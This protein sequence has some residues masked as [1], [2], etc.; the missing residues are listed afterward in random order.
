MTF[1]KQQSP[2]THVSNVLA[3]FLFLS[4]ICVSILSAQAQDCLPKSD[5]GLCD[6]QAP[7]MGFD[8]VSATTSFYPAWNESSL[9]SISSLDNYLDPTISTGQ[10]KFVDYAKASSDTLENGHFAIP[11][12]AENAYLSQLP[13]SNLK[14]AGAATA[15]I[16]DSEASY[17]AMLASYAQYRAGVSAVGG[18]ASLLA[19]NF[20]NALPVPELL[21]GSAGATAFFAINV[22]DSHISHVSNKFGAISE[23]SRAF[24]NESGQL[25][26]GVSG[27]YYMGVEDPC[28]DILN[29][30]VKNTY[31]DA[32]DLLTQLSANPTGYG[33][34]A[35]LSNFSENDISTADYLESQG[36]PVKYTFLD[37]SN[38]GARD[39]FNLIFS[40]AGSE[41]PL[42]YTLWQKSHQ[43]E[44]ARSQLNSSIIA[45]SKRAT[46]ALNAANTS[47][48]EFSSSNAAWVLGEDNAEYAQSLSQ[49]DDYFNNATALKSFADG[50]D[51]SEQSYA[52]RK[53][54]GYEMA[55]GMFDAS[56]STY[57]G[58]YSQAQQDTA[59][60]RQAVRAGLDAA[61]AR[62]AQKKQSLDMVSLMQIDN[63]LSR[64]GNLLANSSSGDLYTD[65]ENIAV[66]ESYVSLATDALNGASAADLGSSQALNASLG[67]LS[68]LIDL[69]ETDGVD[70]SFERD[71]YDSLVWGLKSNISQR[72]EEYNVSSGFDLSYYLDTSDS[73]YKGL[74]ARLSEE[75]APQTQR[76][77]AISALAQY[78]PGTKTK[79]DMKG[80]GQYF[81][82]AG[83]IIVTK[84]A[85][86]MENIKSAL[87]R[88][89]ADLPSEEPSAISSRLV[90]TLIYPAIEAQVDSES[91]VS[92]LA[93]IHNPTPLS[94]DSSP[95]GVIA[96]IKPLKF[97]ITEIS[98]P[99]GSDATAATL[100]SPTYVRLAFPGFE[101][102]G[103]KQ[104]TMLAKAKLATS[105]APIIHEQVSNTGARYSAKLKVT[106]LASL[107][108]ARLSL[109][110]PAYYSNCTMAFQGSDVQGYVYNDGNGNYFVSEFG[111]LEN[112][113]VASSLQATCSNPNPYVLSEKGSNV[114]IFANQLNMW[115]DYE[116]TG[117]QSDFSNAEVDITLPGSVSASAFRVEP[118]NPETQITSSKLTVGSGFALAALKLQEISPGKTYAFRIYG[119]SG[120]ASDYVASYI[121]FASERISLLGM[122]GDYS[123]QLQH[124][125]DLYNSGD[126]LGAYAAASA[127]VQSAE[128]NYNATSALAANY[129]AA[130]GQAA[131][132]LSRSKSRYGNLSG[133]FDATDAATL[134]MISRA[135]AHLSDSE[136]SAA[137]GNYAQAL[138]SANLA[139]ADLSSNALID[140]QNSAIAKATSTN[141][142]KLSSDQA[143]LGQSSDAY[144]EV[145]GI[146]SQINEMLRNLP[147]LDGSEFD[148]QV[149]KIAGLEA[150]ATNISSAFVSSTLQKQ[151]GLLDSADAALASSDAPLLALENSTSALSKSKTFKLVFDA[152]KKRTEYLSIA[153]QI[154]KQRS[155]AKSGAISQD[156]L[157]A[158]ASS[159]SS[160]VSLSTSVINESNRLNSTAHS[161]VESAFSWSGNA[162]ALASAAGEPYA[163][164]SSAAVDLAVTAN[165]KYAKADY[166][167]SLL[168]SE[169]S[170]QKS[171]SLMASIPAKKAQA[172]LLPYAAISLLVLA[173]VAA[174][175][176]FGRGNTGSGG[177]E[178]IEAGEPG[179]DYVGRQKTSG[180]R[181]LER[182]N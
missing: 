20:L 147:F 19:F 173:C 134:S 132:L 127:A 55:A 54:Y 4:V 69:A 157:A 23:S 96:P 67:K 11:G 65:Q 171:Q 79:D 33:K 76:Y 109:P 61:S 138:K 137:S 77:A 118:A 95:E 9:N 126:Y 16:S 47:Q 139:L 6:C 87:D 113:G 101:A 89:E 94:S 48:S 60:K 57:S 105:A 133:I 143:M 80:I 98:I 93:T 161:S 180:A 140:F 86:N 41:P 83:N 90:S 8:T 170:I 58:L 1:G 68:R 145:S 130:R 31:A 15:L 26:R 129:E 106:P 150:Q 44:S 14:S 122:A 91:N 81:D 42:L 181:K 104:V 163:T 115:T 85:G 10:T 75:Y 71:A 112:T 12:A 177:K 35:Y 146:R 7:G 24:N 38:I 51:S 5:L 70:V 45:A 141:L 13:A 160:A 178:G 176:V 32:K 151:L 124:S 97:P 39:N 174:Y 66:A 37:Y 99:E 131:V 166:A 17:S 78:M 100:I 153:T 43:V 179:V 88:A 155:G 165:E 120:S 21:V 149:G 63:Y 182:K 74:V 46:G 154:S 159:L 50:I 49:A 53:I 73:L 123:S 119:V 84:A 62:R 27:L 3:S 25:V 125:Q 117:A 29:S 142:K 64:A 148:S 92:I 152:K 164:A 56:A 103:T 135:D 36:S 172:D 167:G 111:P 116:V 102:H 40:G 175:Y 110:V 82:N 22:M 30:D 2:K 72:I 168:A 107:E 28:Y 162:S 52:A 169:E 108:K 158:A 156:S 128:S 59:S 136:K 144:A 34:Y 18:T 121:T 114:T